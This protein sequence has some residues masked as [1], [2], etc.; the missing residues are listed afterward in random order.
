MYLI[1]RVILIVAM[2]VFYVGLAD[3]AL[4][5][6]GFVNLGIVTVLIVMAA[7]RRREALTAFGTARWA[8]AKDLLAAGMLGASR[9]LILGRMMD[10]GRTSLP[11]AQR[12]LLNVTLPSK[13][14]CGEFLASL[15][16]HQKSRPHPA[17]V[18]LPHAIHT[19][20][21]APTGVGKGVSSRFC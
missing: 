7:K 12:G 6:P 9:G 18:R 11:I 14:A 19:A 1:C 17:L 21:F 15:R 3:L 16:F 5:L 2:C 10:D 4:K 20:V 13:Q 8:S